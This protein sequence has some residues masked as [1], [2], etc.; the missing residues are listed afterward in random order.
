MDDVEE[1]LRQHG[2]DVSSL[3][4]LLSRGQEEIYALAVPTEDAVARW[5]ALRGLVGVTGYWPVLG[6]GSQW[7][8]G[9]DEYADYLKSGSTAEILAESERVDLDT[10]TQA[11]VDDYIESV[12]QEL[13]YDNE[14]VGAI[15]YYEDVSGEWPEDALPYT[16]FS[17][18]K[19]SATR[20]PT[21]RSP[22]A[23]VPTAVGWQVPALLRFRAGFV[24][25]AVHV[26][27]ARRW[28]E[29]YGAEIVGMLPDTIEMRVGRPPEARKD[30]L[31]LAKE[32]YVYCSD[33][34]VQG[35]QTLQAL[36]AG[37]QRGTA[38]FFWWD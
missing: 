33:I 36:A 21:P 5:E 22:I 38:W 31:A 6:W 37:L 23:L 20:E 32:Q 12:K 34:V 10:W 24:S 3:S 14:E 27:M 8:E 2:V 26:A 35:T 15:D 30:A 18:P 1:K 17:I 28:N 16:T 7:L 19:D 29:L 13:I 25:P 9:S 11:Q 4:L